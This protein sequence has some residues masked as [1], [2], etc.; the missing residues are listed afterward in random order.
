MINKVENSTPDMV[1]SPV[2][3]V[4]DLF[5]G[6]GALSH[7]F[8]QEGFSIACGYDIDESCR[9]PFEAN[10]AAPATREMPSASAMNWRVDTKKTCARSSRGLGLWM[11]SLL[12]R[13]QGTRRTV[14]MTSGCSA[15]PWSQ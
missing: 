5:C 3:S 9:Y 10:N 13:C 8:V 1:A 14:S 2:A 4:I 15:P 7:G 11:P 6:A 12:D